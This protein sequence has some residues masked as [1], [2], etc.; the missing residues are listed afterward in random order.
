MVLEV[1]K[2]KNMALA[3]GEGLLAASQHGRGH[4]IEKQSKHAILGLFLS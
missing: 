3:P 2:S 4:H 1:G